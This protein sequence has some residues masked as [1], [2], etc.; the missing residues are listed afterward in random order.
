MI[1]TQHEEQLNLPITP[2]NILSGSREAMEPLYGQLLQ[3]T[4]PDS[5]S[6][7]QFCRHACAEFGFTVKQEASANRNIYVYCSR[8]GLPDSQRKPKSAPQRKRPSKR[9]DCRWRVVLTENNQGLWEFR[10]ASSPTAYEHN[11]EM[12]DPKEMV[13]TWPM[14]VNHLIIELARQKMQTH[15]IRD[16]V[17]QRFPHITWNERRFYNRLTE[18]RKRIKQREIIERVQRMLFLTAKMCSLVA[19][20]DEWSMNVENELNRL[21][22]NYIHLNRFNPE[23]TPLVDFNIDQITLDLDQFIKLPS[24]YQS[25]H[26]NSFSSSNDDLED[27]DYHSSSSMIKMEIDDNNSIH[28][29]S[30]NNSQSNPIVSNMTSTSTP[31]NNNNNNATTTTTTH[32]SKKR[33]SVLLDDIPT[34]TNVSSSPPTI[35]TIPAPKGSHTV[36]IPAYTLFVRSHN[37]RSSTSDTSTSSTSSL[38]HRKSFQNDMTSPHSLMDISSPHPQQNL[39][40]NNPSFYSLASPTSPSSSSSVTSSTFPHHPHHHQQQQQHRPSSLSTSPPNSNHPHPS[41]PMMHP[42]SSSTTTTTHFQTSSPPSSNDHH[43]S[44]YMKPNYQQQPPHHPTSIA[45]PHS[46]SNMPLQQAAQIYSMQPFPNYPPNQSSTH[47]INDGF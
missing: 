11:H 21:Y 24:N 18:E 2:P 35:T 7:V 32:S 6:A 15:E 19:A 20:N 39:S 37:T 28:T 12:M 17:K 9:C 10:K 3:H 38:H 27:D 43:P 42:T 34:S 31:N 41:H 26:R 22:D 25:Q 16:I 8:E 29:S 30:T 4:F 1:M 46:F 40:F 44:F 36:Y 47:P 23:T 5:H 33:K 45:H 14:E 13:K